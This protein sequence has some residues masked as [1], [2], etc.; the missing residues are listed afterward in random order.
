MNGFLSQQEHA[1]AMRVLPAPS[2]IGFIFPDDEKSTDLS[3][4]DPE[5]S[6]FPCTYCKSSFV[7][8]ASLARHM[9]YH[10]D[11]IL[12]DSVSQDDCVGNYGMASTLANG[13]VKSCPS[14]LRKQVFAT[15]N[16]LNPILA[17]HCLVKYHCKV[18]GRNVTRK[19]YLKR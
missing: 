13:T 12:K 18:C 4:N 6:E 1:L 16:F 15:G 19:D 3:N 9:V 7:T 10:E 17:S 11:E 8:Q 5:P 14:A 2:G